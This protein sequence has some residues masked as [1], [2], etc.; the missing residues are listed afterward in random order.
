MV[1]IARHWKIIYENS[2][3]G[4]ENSN[5]D[6]FGL[7]SGFGMSWFNNKNVI[8]FGIQSSP[9]FGFFNFPIDE[10]N[11]NSSLPFVSYSRCF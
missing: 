9:L 1:R 5:N 2:F 8:K 7:F 6:L 4:L 11:Q 10:F 3:G